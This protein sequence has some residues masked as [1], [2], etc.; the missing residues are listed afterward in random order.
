V[1]RAIHDLVRHEPKDTDQFAGRIGHFLGE[2]EALRT[3]T[4]HGAWKADQK[5]DV[6]AEAANVKLFATELL[7]RVTDFAFEVVGQS[8]LRKNHVL[9]RTFRHARATRIVEGPSEIQRHIIQ[10]ELFREGV[11]ALELQ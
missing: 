1:L 11:T 6:R 3:L 5:M 2:L 7:H 10:R 9:S 4:Y 8:A